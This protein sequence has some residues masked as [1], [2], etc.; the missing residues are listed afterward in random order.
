MKLKS[1]I[2]GIS[3]LA[4]SLGIGEKA[5]GCGPFPYEPYS[6]NPFCVIEPIRTTDRKGN[7]KA[8]EE[9]LEFWKGYTKGA[10]SE[11][12]IRSYFNNASFSNPRPSE[13][14]PFISWLEKRQDK[15]AVDYI[16][17][18][19]EFSALAD[20]FH[21]SGWEYSEK[22]PA[23][24]KG[25]ADKIER[26]DGG[27][28]F[29]IR[30]DLLRMRVAG[31]LRDDA[32]VME[33]WKRKGE[34][35]PSSLLRDRMGGF[36]GGV[37][38]RQG[39]YPEALDYFYNSGDNNSIAWCVSR[40]VGPDNLQALYQHDPNSTAT[41]YALTDYL[42]YLISN[43]DAGRRL[44]PRDEWEDR[45][46]ID[47]AL[48]QRK[49][50][51]SLCDLALADNRCENRMAWA[52]AKGAIQLT[53]GQTFQGLA[54]LDQA[55]ALK[56]T[57]RTRTALD[58]FRLWALLLN[59]GKGEKEI[60]SRLAS[61]LEKV[62]GRAVGESKKRAEDEIG[63]FSDYDEEEVEEPTDSYLF[64]TTFFVQEAKTHFMKQGQ[65]ARALAVMGM[66]DDLPVAPQNGSGMFQTDIREHIFRTLSDREAL[67]FISLAEHPSEEPLDRY[68]S[69]YA[70]KYLNLA[71][72][73]Y[74]TRL[75]YRNDFG[76]A[77]EYLKKVDTK[78]LPTMAIYPY[79]RRYTVP[80]YYTFNRNSTD[81]GSWSPYYPTNFKALF[82]SQMIEDMKKYEELK[83]DERAE[84]AYRIAANYHQASP[85]GDAWAISD[86]SWTVLRPVNSFNEE[87]MKWLLKALADAKDAHLKCE[88]YY[89][90][91]SSPDTDG[92]GEP[93]F[94]F[95]CTGGYDSPVRYYWDNRSE[96]NSRAMDY[97]MAN[98]SEVKD[99]YLLSQCD[100]LRDYAAS[101]FVAKPEYRW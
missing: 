19:L 43:S 89:G 62:Y 84:A 6:Y 16:L 53:M 42:N 15:E 17:D 101:K 75:L 32:K 86:Y 97:L 40:I 21:N 76:G 66:M 59:S 30:Y 57:E 70:A 94:A 22:N 99:D 44:T 83:G 96:L 11:K 41:L 69:R 35:L 81:S 51:I 2:A 12:D 13:G 3:I 25:F 26:R 72:E 100:V 24:L 64:L 18:C 33:I 49:E 60:D 73:A 80:Y 27:K 68:L 65:P 29:G 85:Q 71:N 58:H 39:K 37:L 45:G 54:T 46:R 48:R 90:I 14:A 56:G 61:E 91:L 55:S 34:K 5:W 50:F 77:L 52:I 82:C 1:Y 47:E 87:S 38:Y 67:S 4:L 8:A 9:T 7:V 88:I 63:K 78:W 36:V 10:V 28:D 98:Y 92:D 20:E 31:A 93:K 95:G 74:A 79:L 23:A